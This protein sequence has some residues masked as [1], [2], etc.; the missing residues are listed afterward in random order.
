[1]KI[2]LKRCVLS[3]LDGSTPAEEIDITVGEGNLTYVERKNMNYVL[4]RGVLD[5]VV[6]GDEVPIDVSFEFTWEYISGQT[7]G[8]GATPT[9]ED[10]LKQLNLASTWVSTDADACRPYSVDL[11]VVHTPSPANCGDIETTTL[12]DFRHE[13]LN[14]DLRAGT[15]SCTGKCNVTEATVARTAQ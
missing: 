2:D 4:D 13:E 1:M 10:A 9:I 14:H 8:S 12:S 3:I 5:D 6:E 7:S 11:R 15:V